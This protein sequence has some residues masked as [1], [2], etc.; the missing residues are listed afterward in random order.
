MCVGFVLGI[1]LI[2]KNDLA[3]LWLTIVGGLIY[4]HFRWLK[5]V[6]RSKTD[7]KIKAIP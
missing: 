7:V 2:D 6:N 4:L 1:F 5:R 3:P